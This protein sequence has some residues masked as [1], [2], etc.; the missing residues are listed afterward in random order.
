MIDCPEARRDPPKRPLSVG[1]A[2]STAPASRLGSPSRPGPPRRPRTSENTDHRS[3]N[4]ERK[5]P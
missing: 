1:L 5:R 3:P 2:P 4:A